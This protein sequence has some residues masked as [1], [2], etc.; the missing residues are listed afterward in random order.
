MTGLISRVMSALGRLRR[1]TF[2]HFAVAGGLLFLIDA[3]RAKPAAETIVVTP[4][5]A[6]GL[7]SEREELRGSPVS[8]DE[9]PALIARY[10]NDEILLREAYERELYRRDGVIR[11]RLLELMRFLLVEEPSEPTD[12]E[13]QEY[14]S[15][16]GDVYRTPAAVTFSHVF[17]S[18]GESAPS[19]TLDH[20]TRDRLLSRLRTGADFRRLGDRFWLGQT[21]EGYVEPQL[22]QLLGQE[23]ARTVM[24]LPLHEWSGP[25]LSNRGTHF[26]RVDEHRP[27][28][29]P[30]FGELVPI[31]RS[32]W[33]ATKREELL[34]GKVDALR[35]QY[36]VDIETDG[37]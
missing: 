24:Q 23:F 17:Y 12:G 4:G 26:V 1:E 31:L 35:S 8:S 16:H 37:H 21:L 6:Y 2:V 29:M 20:V 32:D 25:I 33:L 34:A 14:L 5:I 10:V 3:V 22:A 7:V 11:K 15:R 9:R 19:D 13:L 36:R 28:E 18:A 30:A 27:P